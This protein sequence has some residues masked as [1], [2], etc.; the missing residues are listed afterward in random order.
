M[1]NRSGATDTLGWTPERAPAWWTSRRF[2]V[3]LILASMVPL[4]WPQIPPL[5]D[6]PNHIGRYRVEL[7]LAN[8]PALQRWFD[9]RWAIVGNLGIDLLVVPFV[10][11]FGLELGVKLIVLAIPPLTVTGML[12]IAREVHGRLPATITFALPLAY[13]F[14]F[15]FGFVNFSLGIA[16]ALLLF[17]LWLRLGRLGWSRARAALLL[18]AGPVLW[19]AHAFGWGVLGILVFAAALVEAWRPERRWWRAT[20]DAVKTCLPLTPAA[21]L[22]L[23]WGGERAGELV[24]H[25]FFE[26]VTK[27]AHALAILRDWAMVPDILSALLLYALVGLAIA[28]RD[29]RIRAMPAT[30]AAMLLLIFLVMPEMLL[31]SAYAAMRLIPVVVAVGLL[32]IVPVGT[33]RWHQ[34]VA[35]AGCLFFAVRLAA[36]TVHY[37]ALDRAWSQQLEALDHV[38]RGARIFSMVGMTCGEGWSNRRTRHL[39]GIAT[40]RREAVING[41]WTM[42]GA[43]LLSIRPAAPAGFV[44][45]GTEV[46]APADCAYPGPYDVASMQRRLPRD[47][48]DYVWLIDVPRSRW[49]ADPGFRPVWQRENGVLY[50]IVNGPPRT[51][52]AQ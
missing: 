23:D 21:L 34:G 5:T 36:H 29:F 19:I 42:P 49:P 44:E 38:P 17:G 46:L 16:L 31:G 47:Q 26:P 25:R 8:S 28:R 41:Q 39:R 22:F 7:D 20:A 33:R 48:F 37:A 2:A 43:Q 12:L 9:F 3:F 11:L 52:Q 27:L 4:L 35:I 13:T 32:G 51:L 10:K 6:L 14:P 50:Q 1:M 15:Q 45:S 24:T 18:I 40:A 30:A